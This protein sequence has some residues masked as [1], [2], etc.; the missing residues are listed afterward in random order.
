MELTV[1]RSQDRRRM[2]VAVQADNQHEALTTIRRA[3]GPVT[4]ALEQVIVRTGRREVDP[5]HT[6]RRGNF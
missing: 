4:V 1:I 5:H 3:I 6:R 2:V